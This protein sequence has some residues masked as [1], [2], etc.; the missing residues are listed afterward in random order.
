MSRKSKIHSSLIAGSMIWVLVALSV[1]N[2]GAAQPLTP[3]RAEYKVKISVLSGKLTTEFRRTSDG[4]S[5]KSTIEPAGL[6]N[7]F[8]NGS[9]EESSTFTV[10]DGGVVP[11]L[12]RSMDT[13]T[14][15]QKEMNFSFDWD[16]HEVAGTIGEANYVI[17]L[18]GPVHDRV[19][20]QY[21]LMYELMNGS[22]ADNYVMLNEEELRPIVVSNIGK[23]QVKVP[24]GTFEAVGIQHRTEDSSRVS[25]L[26]CVEKLGFLPVIIEQHRDGKLRARAVLNEYAPIDESQGG[27][28]QL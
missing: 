16:R 22:P 11:A 7:I 5:A 12:Y 25:T 2:A 23:K 15:D 14:K 3:Y 6:A 8:L 10:T 1:G 4:Y 17:P 20:I 21:E 27:S 9:I 26:W 24:F 18:E 13:L 19:T 28:D